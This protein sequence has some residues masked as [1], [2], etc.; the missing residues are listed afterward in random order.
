VV[1]EIMKY[2]SGFILANSSFSW[3]AGFL[4]ITHASVVVAPKPWFRNIPVSQDLVPRDWI[5][6]DSEWT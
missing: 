2:G 1:I 4:R 5:T 6:Q 3:W